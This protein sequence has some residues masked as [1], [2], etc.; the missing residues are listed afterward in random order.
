MRIAFAWTAFLLTTVSGLGQEPAHI[1]ELKLPGLFDRSFMGGLIEI[2]DRPIEQLQLRVL[3][4]EERGITYGNIFVKINGKGAGNVFDRRPSENGVV[5]TMDKSRL[6]LRP[7][8]LLDR[9]E[10]VVEAIGQDRR[11]RR[12]YQ[13]WIIRANEP[14]RNVWF[15]Y[16]AT[17]SPADPNGAP[18]D[19]ILEQP[20]QPPVIAVAEKSA[21][22]RLKGL[23][24]AAE[25]GTIVT[26]NGRPWLAKP[27]GSP[28]TPFD[29]TVVISRDMKELVLEALDK[30]GNR[31]SV[32]IP[33]IVQSRTPP[34]I[35][36]GG[37][38]YAIVV[39]ISRFATASQGALPDL[40][41]AAAGARQFALD[42]QKHAGVAPDNLRLLIDDQA[43]PDQIRTAFTTF[44]AKATGDD[45]LFVY[46]A[47]YGLHDPFK[48]EN[49]YLAAYGSQ[50]KALNS[51]AIDYETLEM[52]VSRNVRCNNSIFVFDAGHEVS[53]LPAQTG[54]NMINR[55]L[56]NL[57]NEQE[58]R[59]VLVSGST[60]EISLRRSG[61]DTALFSDWLADALAG[62][63]DV[64]K[65]NVITAAEL[66]SFIAEKVR[67]E[68]K[69]QQIPRFRLASRVAE[70]P[71]LGTGGGKASPPK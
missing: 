56:L 21:R 4:T 35:R 6:D 64:N 10:N 58:G 30:R 31:R 67:A 57:F 15:A 16:A 61:T 48:P 40:P 59:A 49:L 50:M 32:T 41:G 62:S 66:F 19:V 71:I 2:P 53:G 13:N 22:V 9:R 3:G 20:A 37:R 45:M 51:T 63:A 11:G 24:S 23:V 55:Y 47:S 60:N 68:S 46:V 69:D 43:T 65:D 14:G 52:L 7:D 34:K 39:G 5:L 27:T 1:F 36:M 25:P 12:Y 38:R 18:P 42:L 54:K 28:T 8:Q 26:L 33:I 70:Q 44:A 29:D 17:M